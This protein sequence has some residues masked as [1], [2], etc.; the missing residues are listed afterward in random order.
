MKPPW[1]RQVP[2]F[3]AGKPWREFV[4]FVGYFF[5]LILGIAG[6]IGAGA[7]GVLLVIGSF[8]G[9]LLI[10]DGWGFR[11]RLP[12]LRSANRA[13]AATGWGL[14]L[15]VWFGAVGLTAPSANQSLHKSG[16]LA[17]ASPRTAATPVATADA[18]LTPTAPPI[19]VTVASTPT[20]TPTP[21][22]LTPPPTAEPTPTPTPTPSFN[23]CGAP[24]NPWHYNFCGGDRIY[25]PPATFCA[26][27]SCT[28]TFWSGDGYVVQCQDSLFSKSGGT[29]GSCSH[30]DGYRRPLYA[31]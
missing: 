5:M 20:P 3:R 22:H 6:A 19:P 28:G 12:L 13:L 18:T 30:H 16:G 17:F 1:W 31:P 4:A 11:S 23:Y 7:R 9:F 14:F 8:I 2:G 29:S 24:V 26:Y 27:F 10:T 21:T 25:L 15:V